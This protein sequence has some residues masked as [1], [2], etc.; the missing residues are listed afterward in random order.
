[1]PV[2]AGFIG[3]EAMARY[4]AESGLSSYRNITQLAMDTGPIVGGIALAAV[5]AALI[6]SGAP[7]LLGTATMF[8]NDWL[9]GSDN[10][11]PEKKLK[12]YKLTAD[13]FAS[14]ATHIAWQAHITSVL[15]LLLLGFA[16]V[17]PPAIPIVF[18]FYW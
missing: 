14:I 8:V 17:V 5:L 15:Q 12:D 10:L 13:A 4:G 6:S 18:I 1:M 11:S 16:M 9:P 3:L 7:I 2:L